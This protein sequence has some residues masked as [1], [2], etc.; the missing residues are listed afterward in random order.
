MHETLKKIN[1]LIK[2]KKTLP[3]D[4]L[5]WKE[6][7]QEA[8]NLNKELQKLRETESRRNST[9]QRRLPTDYP[10]PSGQSWNHI[11]KMSIM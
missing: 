2:N 3:I 8:L 5:I 10:V 1:T 11:H 9:L 7:D 6:N 4:L